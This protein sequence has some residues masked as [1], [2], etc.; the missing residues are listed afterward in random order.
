MLC[1]SKRAF[2]QNLNHSSSKSF[3][4]AVKQLNQNCSTMPNLS[5][6]DSTVTSDKDNAHFTSCFNYS[7]PVLKEVHVITPDE[8]PSYLL[9]H[10]DEV[11]HMLSSIDVSK[12]SGPDGIGARMLK[13]T[14]ASIAPA[15]TNLFNISLSHGKVPSEWKTACV[16]PIP[17]SSKLSDHANFRPVSLLSILSKLLE[18]Y[19]QTLLLEHLEL[20]SPISDEQWGFTKG[21]STVGAHLTATNNWHK[22]L[23]EGTDVC[24]VFLDLSKAFDKV[25]HGPLMDK[26]SSLDIDPYVLNWL[27][28][29]LL[30]RDQHVVV[31][32]ESSVA[33]KVVSGVPQGSVLGPLLFLIYIDGIS[34]ISLGA[35]WRLLYA[36]DILV[37]CQIRNAM[38]YIIVQDVLDCLEV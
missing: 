10:K 25:P 38:D 33:T 31:N 26:L 2:F 13:S 12:A 36:D 11:T 28:D 4:K 19:V 14:A 9:C 8:P 37:Y 6:G 35:G 7:V 5:V 3:W 23:E 29:Y 22:S 24:A 15:I 32:G 1:N 21:K 34:E 27:G 17:K 30:Q 16:T 20:H 18:K